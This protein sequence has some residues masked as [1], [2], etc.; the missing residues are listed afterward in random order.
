MALPLALLPY[1]TPPFLKLDGSGVYV[2]NDG[3]KIYSYLT[4]LSTPQSLYTDSGASVAYSNPII[5]DSD[6]YP[7]SESIFVLPNGYG[8]VIKDSANVTLKTFTF[9]EDV[10]AT[11]LNQLGVIQTTGTTATGTGPYTVVAATDNFVK[12]NTATTPYVVQLPAATSRPLGTT[13]NGLP[14]VIKNISASVSVRV[15]PAGSDTLESIAA[16]YTL[17]AAVS[18]L[19]P[20]VTLVSDGV[21]GWWITGGIGMRP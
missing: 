6:G 14:L 2:P 15:T 12:V 4:N 3:G 5:L 13:G 7:S 8:I 9:I 18:P 19:M 17:P 1:L 21:S 10:G 11:F 20:T 16:Y